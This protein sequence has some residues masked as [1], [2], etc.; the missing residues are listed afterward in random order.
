MS[1][2][3][4]GDTA[5]QQGKSRVQRLTAW[6]KRSRLARAL[7]RYGAAY[8]AL[9]TGGIAYAALF[10]IFAGLTV[11]FS[12]F[13]AVLGT[14]S[15]LQ[16]A[17]LDAL[18]SALPGIVQTE[19]NP[20]APV[21]VESLQ[22]P[23]QSSIVVAVIAFLV[24]LNS[25]TTVMSSLRA[26]IRAMFGIVKPGEKVV[27]AK[28]RD[29]LG[30]VVLALAVVLTAVLGTAVGAAGSVVSEALGLSDNAVADFF[31][32]LLGHLVALGVDFLVLLFLIRVLA[33]ARPPRRDLLIGSLVVSVAAGV[34]RFLGTALVSGSVS[35]N[36]LLAPF[37]VIVVL[38]LWV[39]LI[40]RVLLTACAWTANPPAPPEVTDDVITHAEEHPNYVTESEP[41]TLTW[42]HDPLTGRI[43]PVPPPEP[44]EYWGG[45]I[46]WTKRKWRGFREA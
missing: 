20:N 9:L 4:D 5:V 44:E 32:R 7:A 1:E 8:G 18:S 43:R 38:L 40:V 15:Q 45:L 31:L 22:F 14:N 46:G 21:T 12:V 19:D 30:F 24:L 26:G 11:A 25:A 34:I 13:T 10:S 29:L 17:V 41:E 6:W 39:N 16:E 2:E 33:G 3:S 42:D 28:L 23:P 36:P 27:L 37:A 35:A